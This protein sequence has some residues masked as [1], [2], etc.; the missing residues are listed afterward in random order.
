[1]RVL[2]YIGF[3]TPANMF[4]KHNKDDNTFW[5]SDQ[6]SK[7]SKTSYRKTT[8]KTASLWIQIH[9]SVWYPRKL[10]K[11]GKWVFCLFFFYEIRTQKLVGN[12]DKRL[13]EASQELSPEGDIMFSGLLISVYNKDS[14]LD[15]SEQLWGI[16]QSNSL[17]F[18]QVFWLFC[19]EG[20]KVVIRKWTK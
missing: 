14:Q 6:H 17:I 2:L 1:M 3:T 4:N 8:F 18:P 20:N 13:S 11:L 9:W 19:A 5:Y 10:N 7:D 12:E 15:F 16:Q